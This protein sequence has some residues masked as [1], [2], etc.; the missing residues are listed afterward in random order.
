MYRNL[1]STMELGV[2]YQDA[3]GKIIK[4]NSAAE[5]ILGFSPDQASGMTSESD[6]WRALRED[7]SQFP[8]NEHPAM[9]ALSTGKTVKNVVMGVYNPK[10]KRR[11]WINI[12]AVPEFRSGKKKPYRVFTTFDDITEKKEA[13]EKLKLVQFGIDNSMIAV[14]RIDEEA[15]IRYVNRQACKSLGYTEEELLRMKIIDIDPNF[16]YESW[17]KHRS[18]VRERGGSSF[19]T[20]HKRKDGSVFPVEVTVNYHVLGDDRFSFSF[21]KD[22]TERQETEKALRESKTLLSD[23]MKIARLAHWEFDIYSKEFV[24]NDCFYEV[25]HATAEKVGGYRLPPE[26]YAEL[27]IY[28]E[29]RTL[30]ASEIRK[31]IESKTKNYTSQ[32]EHRILYYDGST[33]YASV[34]I[35]G[36]RGADGRAVRAFG[37]LQDISERK[38][39]ED[40]LVKAKETAIENDRLKTAF[41]NN[42]SH[43]IRTPL[44]VI[45]GYAGLINEGIEDAGM[46]KLMTEP[47]MRSANQLQK[48]IEDVLDISRIEAGQTNLKIEETD[49]NELLQQVLTEHNI[50]AKSK[51]LDLILGCKLE[52]GRTVVVTDKSKLRQILSNLVTNAI[53]YTEAGHVK[54]NACINDSDVC[55]SIEDTGYGIEAKYFNTIFERFQRL[56]RE[57]AGNYHS[58]TQG[59]TGLGLA[60]S[61]ALTEMLGG[62]IW[63]NSEIG[64][65]S[66]FYF[67]IPRK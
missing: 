37:T 35:F 41:L 31:A 54:V 47:I 60:I 25:L 17:R 2:V 28:P 61:K 10:K 29:D 21:A 4:M 15:N 7:G 24:F 1:F 53:K 22:I 26:R 30:V 38:K 5:E 14:F 50:L 20:E 55:F 58:I 65:G 18:G 51:N 63:L 6:E 34:Q 8:G 46:L 67:T 66:V 32:I 52:N 19:I 57:P 64:K 40:A 27:F 45:F 16:D 11:I 23:A 42:V 12:N 39:T 13:E 59:G 62:K 49:V 36:E 43:E 48:I 33:G 9:V 3:R 44:N 56:D